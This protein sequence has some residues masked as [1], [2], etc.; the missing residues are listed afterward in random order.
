MLSGI[1]I[2]HS[3]SLSGIKNART[4]ST[5][6]SF[7]KALHIISNTLKAICNINSQRRPSVCPSVQSS[8]CPSSTMSECCLS[9][10]L[11]CA[12]KC[13][14]RKTLNL[15]SS[16]HHA[17]TNRINTNSIGKHFSFLPSTFL[18]SYSRYI[19]YT[20]FLSRFIQTF[21]ARLMVEL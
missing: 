20:G 15:S 8:V 5:I 18:S 11:N 14:R 3:L 17:R 2:S 1:S 6:A 13:Q 9:M 4:P 7:A 16:S 10:A 12:F 21:Y 19:V